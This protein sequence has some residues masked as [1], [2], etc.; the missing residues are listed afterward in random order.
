MKH[1]WVHLATTYGEKGDEKERAK[2]GEKLRAKAL[3]YAKDPL[4]T[5]DE[6]SKDAGDK[7]QFIR[8]CLEV[9]DVLKNKNHRSQLIVELDQSMSVLQH[10]ALLRGDAALADRVNMEKTHRD[11]YQ[12]VADGIDDLR[13][14]DARTRRKIVKLAFLGWVYGGNWTT[15]AKRYHGNMTEIPFL[16]GLGWHGRERL[17]VKVVAALNGL[18][19]LEA[20]KRGLRDESAR[21][22]GMRRNTPHLRWTT[23]SGFEVRYYK[24]ETEVKRP[25]IQALKDGESKGGRPETLRLV[26]LKPTDVPDASKLTSAIAPTVV[27]SIDAAVAH[28]VLML[29]GE[30]GAYIVSVHDAF[31]V[32]LHNVGKVARLFRGYLMELYRD[33]LHGLH[34]FNRR[35]RQLGNVLQP[36]IDDKAYRKFINKCLTSPHIID[37]L[38]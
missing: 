16:R 6:W 3:R 30:E 4:G 36:I 21:Q 14:L 33:R 31:G 5:Y 12:E 17:G 26:A 24:Q 37:G 15:A 9:R 22:Q 38:V 20:Y 11:T 13:E 27:H 8:A 35:E 10:I 23:P 19:G 34:Y 29:A 7:W 25:Y 1:L 18:A 32:H 28:H 2:T